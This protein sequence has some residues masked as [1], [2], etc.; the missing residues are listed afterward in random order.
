MLIKPIC[1]K[2]D[3]S[4]KWALQRARTVNVQIMSRQLESF[5]FLFACSMLFRVCMDYAEEKLL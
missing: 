1:S 3:L 2:F 5:V 4:L